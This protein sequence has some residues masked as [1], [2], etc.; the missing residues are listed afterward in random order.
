MEDVDRGIY[1]FDFEND[2]TS[3]VVDYVPLPLARD[4]LVWRAQLPPGS[5]RWVRGVR[6]Y[7]YGWSAKSYPLTKVRCGGA[8]MFMTRCVTY[9]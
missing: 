6:H 9:A 4:D 3:V 1:Q 5:P 2:G 7:H 8:Q